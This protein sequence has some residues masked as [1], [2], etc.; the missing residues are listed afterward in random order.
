MTFSA[1]IFAS[2]FSSIFDENGSQNGAISVRHAERFGDLFSTF[3]RHR[4]FDAFWSPLGSLLA[5]FW[6]PLAS[7]LAPAGSL[8]ALPLAPF[9]LT[10]GVPWLTFGTLC[11]TF[12]HPGIHFLIFAVSC[13]HF[14]YFCL[15]F[16]RQK[17]S[18]CED[19][20]LLARIGFFLAN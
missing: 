20:F 9:W 17:F 1:S 18:C 5:P 16:P 15:D 14:W 19:F 6:L 11:F 8:L 7:L 13:P 3:S 12:A 2:I 10:F 4:F